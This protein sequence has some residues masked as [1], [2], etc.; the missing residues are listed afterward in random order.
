MSH[1]PEWANITD[2]I[3]IDNECLRLCEALN[4][5]PGIETYSS[6]C[7]HG[8]ETFYVAFHATSVDSL[9][10]LSTVLG[11][12]AIGVLSAWRIALVPPKYPDRC[13]FILEGPRGQPAYT[14][15]IELTK[16]IRELL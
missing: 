10:L 12:M 6:C 11:K 9:R 13:L 14:D 7:G 5:L 16:L 15:A 1:Y 3:G 2:G 8:R 4:K